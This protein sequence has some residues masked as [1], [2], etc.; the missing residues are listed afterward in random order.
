M[1]KTLIIATS[2]MLA[3]IS[4]P[5]AFAQT[6]DKTVKDKV[7]RLYENTRKETKKDVD[8]TAKVADKTADKA[9]NVYDKTK[10]GTKKVAHKTAEVTDKAV[11]KT[12]NFYDKAKDGVVKTYKKVTDKLK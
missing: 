5:A 6:K 4:Y 8:K 7:E 12:K 10:D 2:A 9:E 1:K 11:D 3:F